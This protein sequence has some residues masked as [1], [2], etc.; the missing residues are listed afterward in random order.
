MMLFKIYIKE[1][2]RWFYW[3]P[4]RMAV[5]F[6]PRAITYRLVEKIGRFVA[7]I[8]G[9][10]KGRVAGWIKRTTGLSRLASEQLA[11]STFCHYY[12]NS[13]DSLLYGKIS[14]KNVDTYTEYEG[15]EYLDEALEGGKG[16]I[17]LYPHFGNEEYLMPAIGHK[18]YTVHQIASR[19]EPEPLVGSLFWLANKVRQFAFRMRIGVREKLPVGF[20]YIDRSIR[21][22]F[23]KLKK[24]EVV[25]LAVDGR[26]GK[27]WLD[28]EYLGQ[29]AKIST[30]SMKLAQATGA[31][32]LP[33]VTFRSGLYTHTLRIL[34]P[35]EL[36]HTDDKDQDIYDN[37]K[38]A[39]TILEPHMLEH[40]DQYAKF[41]LLDVSLFEEEG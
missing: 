15:L 34:P 9:G 8:S 5:G 10:K 1:F 28:I 22:T 27:K 20:I 19:W 36:C 23:R 7:L 37:T 29:R 14:A 33:C 31:P 24:N 30:G 12:K 38:R 18:G 11:V 40:I 13:L 25:L 17:I 39:L 3:A 16:A 4:M 21:D 41:K 32:V 6:L 26:E 35:L 2:L